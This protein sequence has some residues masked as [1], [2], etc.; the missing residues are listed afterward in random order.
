MVLYAYPKEEHE[1][2][3]LTAKKIEN[4]LI[5]I[6]TD[7]G[8]EFDPTQIPDADITLSAEERSIGGLGIFLIRQIMNTIEYQRIDGKNVLTLGKDL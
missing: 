4:Q 5:F 7:A 3:T 1:I 2:I 6:L 8:K